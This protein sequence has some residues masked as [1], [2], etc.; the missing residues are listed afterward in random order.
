[1]TKTGP[2]AKFTSK[3]EV[4]ELC[5]DISRRLHYLNRTAMG[6]SKFVWEFADMMKRAGK[7][8]ADHYDDK[9]TRAAF[10]DGYVAGTIERKDMPQALFALMYPSDD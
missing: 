7:V 3:E 4:E 5:R 10:G 8:F 2:N 6:E 1:M 9:T